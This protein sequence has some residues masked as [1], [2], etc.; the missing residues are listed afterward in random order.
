MISNIFVFCYPEYAGGK[1]LINSLGLSNDSLFQSFELAKKQLRGEFSPKDKINY[2]VKNICFSRVWGDIGLGDKSLSEFSNHNPLPKE[3]IFF[4]AHNIT[5]LSTLLKKYTNANIII[6]SNTKEF[7]KRRNNNSYV[8]EQNSIWSTFKKGNKSPL[9]PTNKTTHS[10]LFPSLI[11]KQFFDYTSNK[12]NNI[13]YW[14]CLWFFEQALTIK[15]I[16]NLYK[17]YNIKE[18]NLKYLTLYYNIWNHSHK[19]YS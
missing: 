18:V 19:K 6:L 11:E 8:N 2:I 4:T 9:A 5:E 15:H 16:I 13:S 1:F 10:V 17:K 12:T 7:I 3:N 14:N